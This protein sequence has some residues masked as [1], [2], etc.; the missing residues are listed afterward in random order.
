MVAVLQS[1]QV[2]SP[3]VHQVV[4]K[5]PGQ[6]WVRGITFLLVVYLPF[7]QLLLLL[8]SDGFADKLSRIIMLC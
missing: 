5:V 4:R 1:V 6:R 2:M 8:W 7:I 3:Q